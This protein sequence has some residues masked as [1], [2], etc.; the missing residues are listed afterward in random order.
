M[1]E[2]MTEEQV[3]ELTKKVVTF[4]VANTAKESALLY[5][6][7]QWVF[8]CNPIEFLQIFE[9]AGAATGEEIEKWVDEAQDARGAG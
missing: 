6:N 5:P 7:P 9:A 8:S 4:V 3:K 2:G 1:E